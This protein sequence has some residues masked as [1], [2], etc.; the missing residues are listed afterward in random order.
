MSGTLRNNLSIVF[1]N[2]PSS[3]KEGFI[4]DLSNKNKILI[5]HLSTKKDAKH[6]S[7]LFLNNISFEKFRYYIN[8][9]DSDLEIKNYLLKIIHNN[10]SKQYS[11]F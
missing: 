8:P 1:D 4:E 7:E 6:L 10:L 9:Y 5:F 3:H 11:Y 2:A